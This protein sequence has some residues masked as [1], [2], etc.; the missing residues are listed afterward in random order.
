VVASK[1]AEVWK[2][3]RAVVDMDDATLARPPD[4]ADKRKISGL[5]KARSSL[6]G[7]EDKYPRLL[8]ATT[9]S[10]QRRG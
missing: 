7:R 4:E 1:I 8:M 3:T 5:C 10:P 2:T 9:Q 6:L